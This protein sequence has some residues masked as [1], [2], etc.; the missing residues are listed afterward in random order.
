VDVVS[1]GV[2]RLGP[3]RDDKALKGQQFVDH[4]LRLQLY[5]QLNRRQPA[6]IPGLAPSER[7]IDGGDWNRPAAGLLL[8]FR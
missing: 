6:L 7:V 8:S 5:F 1:R 2:H 3:I 4:G